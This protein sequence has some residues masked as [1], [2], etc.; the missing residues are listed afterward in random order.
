MTTRSRSRSR[1]SERT[2]PRSRS[3]ACRIDV[4]DPPRGPQPVQLVS[5]GVQT[6]DPVTI[7]SVSIGVQTDPPAQLVST[8][9]QTSP[10]TSMMPDIIIDLTSDSDEGR[11]SLIQQL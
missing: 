6:D 9:V 7:V 10:P 2:M 3:I 4:I 11:Y 1:V 8:G 5:S